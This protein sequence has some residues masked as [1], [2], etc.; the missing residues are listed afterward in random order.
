M[1]VAAEG[2]A[3]EYLEIRLSGSGGQG[4]ILAATLLADA[5]AQAGRRVVQT[6]SYGPEA[7]GGASKAE[8]IVSDEEIDYPEVR[9]P[10][11]TL[12]LSQPAYDQYAALTAE[13]GLVVVDTGLI[14]TGE[15]NGA[16]RLAGATFTEIATTRLG[17]A[18]ATNVVALGAVLALTGLAPPESVKEALE[19]RLPTKIVELNIRALDLGRDA[20]L[21][22]GQ[23]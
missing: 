15:I 8:V 21:E 17:K 11:V 9:S 14:R 13:G 6:Q 12:C 22:A 7:R 23:A 18:V 5:C 19:R 16:F 2:S 20:V 10:E 1:P 3:R 4:I